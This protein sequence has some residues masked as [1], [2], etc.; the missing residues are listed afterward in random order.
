M[1]D[2]LPADYPAVLT[3]LKDRVRHSRTRAVVAVNTELIALYLEIGRHL[4]TREDTWGGQIVER[5]A[6]DLRAE[7][8][9]MTGFSRTNLYNMRRVYLAWEDGGEIVQQLVGQI[10]WGHHVVLVS[11]LEEPAER[12]WYLTKTVSNGWSRAMLLHQIETRLYDRQGKALTNFE[13]TLPPAESDIVQQTL[14]DPYV[15]DFLDLHESA[16]ERDLERALMKHVEDF[17]LEL[18]VGFALYGRQVPIEAAGRTYFVDLLFYHVDLRCFVV[19]ELKAVPFEPEFAGKLNF[20]LSAVDD[21]FR[22][23]GDAPS[24][25]LLLCK[26]K[27]EVLVE[28]ALRDQGKPMGVAEWTT[29]LVESLPDDL[30]GRLPTPDQLEAELAS[31]D[32]A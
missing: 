9:E 32:D 26:S 7:F 18:G 3:E 21:R 2:L 29:R 12:A 28:Y 6:R 23:E 24:I 16:R 30:K 8:P 14:K 10:P 17:L 15:F 19:V 4:A 25:G 27:E 13:A 1:T 20:Y 5:L 22:R 11:K 31:D